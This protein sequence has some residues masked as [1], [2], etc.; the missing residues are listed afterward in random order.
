MN[1]SWRWWKRHLSFGKVRSGT[2][3]QPFRLNSRFWKGYVLY[4]VLS[5]MIE[6]S[7]TRI[8]KIS[9]KMIKRYPIGAYIR[10]ICKKKYGHCFLCIQS[11]PGVLLHDVVDEHGVHRYGEG[12]GPLRGPSRVDAYAGPGL[13]TGIYRPEIRTFHSVVFC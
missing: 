13:W 1:L 11:L 6:D 7:S 4:C 8:G 3:A 12:F 9:K 5:F 2:V 10:G